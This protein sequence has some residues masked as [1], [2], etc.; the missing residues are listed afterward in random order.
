LGGRTSSESIKGS[1]PSE[2]IERVGLG[3]WDLLAWTEILSELRSISSER[4]VF[5]MHVFPVNITGEEYLTESAEERA[6]KI[7][8]S[9]NTC[10]IIGCPK[11]NP[12]FDYFYREVVRAQNKA[13]NKLISVPPYEFKWW[14]PNDSGWKGK[15]SFSLLDVSD[16][17]D[18]GIYGTSEGMTLSVTPRKLIRPLTRTNP[19]ED[20]IDAGMLVLSLDFE[21]SNTTVVA[22]GGLGGTATLGSVKILLKKMEY[23]NDVIRISEYKS[24]FRVVLAKFRKKD[25]DSSYDDRYLTDVELIGEGAFKAKAEE[26]NKQAQEWREII[27]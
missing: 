21:N 3:H 7:L 10:L 15:N 19:K 12:I 23:L 16:P 1:I 17:M 25:P 27:K 11:T 14:P 9:G 26:M 13:Q 22:C 24:L 5:N 8:T 4:L 18:Q 6:K 2:G 20:L